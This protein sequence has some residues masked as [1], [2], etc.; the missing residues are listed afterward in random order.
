MLIY[1]CNMM[2]KLVSYN[3]FGLQYFRY[4]DSIFVT[5]STANGEALLIS[6]L[7]VLRFGTK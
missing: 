7:V 5:F 4:T 1:V 6:P 3:S 2:S